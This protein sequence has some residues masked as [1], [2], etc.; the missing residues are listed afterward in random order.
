MR[1]YIF[2]WM[3][4]F[5]NFVISSSIMGTSFCDEKESGY[6]TYLIKRSNGKAYVVSKVIHCFISSYI[7]FVLGLLLWILSMR[8]FLPWTTVSDGAFDVVSSMGMG[9]L[10]EDR[11][12]IQYYFLYCSGVGMMGGILSAVTFCSSLLVSNRMF[13]VMSSVVIYYVNVSYLEDFSAKFVE[14]RFNKVLYFPIHAHQSVRKI[15]LQ[16]VGYSLIV[17]VIITMISY[18]IISRRR[19]E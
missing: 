3:I 4:L 9:N 17:C 13:A 5:I 1:W 12:Y 19:H 8:L 10:L 6:Y 2:I 14:W 11:K 18:I 16:G 15:V 7:I